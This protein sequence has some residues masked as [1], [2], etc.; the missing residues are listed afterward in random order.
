MGVVTFIVE[1]ADKGLDTVATSQFAAVAAELE[2]AVVGPDPDHL[3][4]ERRLRNGVDGGV[5]LGGRVVDG[6]TTALFVPLALRIV[7][8]EIGRD[9]LPGL[10][11]VGGLEDT[12]LFVGSPQLSGGA[13]IDRITI[14]AV[15]GDASDA[16]GRFETY[17]GP[18]VAA[19]RGLVHPGTH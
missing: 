3:A 15:D 6:Q 1:A 19:I 10:A 12:P 7:R 16:F 11:A 17:Q 18:T 5:V 9:L 8:G 4:V 13:D 14:V 2:V